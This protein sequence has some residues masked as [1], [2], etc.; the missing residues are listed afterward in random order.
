MTVDTADPPLPL[1]G[2]MLELVDFIRDYIATHGYPPSMNE[3]ALALGINPVVCHRLAIECVRRGGLTHRR[4]AAR[5]WLPVDAAGPGPK[6]RHP[7]G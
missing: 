6:R 5:S 2:R 3:A 7:R 1:S 4:K